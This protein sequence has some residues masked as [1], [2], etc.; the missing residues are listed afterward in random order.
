VNGRPGMGSLRAQD[1]MRLIIGASSPGVIGK[2][3]AV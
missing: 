1:A 3:R 2:T